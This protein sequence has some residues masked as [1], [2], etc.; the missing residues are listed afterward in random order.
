MF[1]NYKQL[2]TSK[3]SPEN[4]YSY[5]CQNGN[6]DVWVEMYE[7]KTVRGHFQDYPYLKKQTV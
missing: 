5:R 6:F 3:Y 1:Q 7:L 2:L 4:P